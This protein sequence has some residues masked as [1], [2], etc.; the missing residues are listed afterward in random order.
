LFLEACGDGG[1]E[2]I[3]DVAVDVVDDDRVSIIS[4]DR[5]GRV[6]NGDRGDV[7]AE[8]GSD[9]NRAPAPVRGD[10]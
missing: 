8:V 6:S 10:C 5:E 4:P 2:D 3:H 1:V 7:V 9:V